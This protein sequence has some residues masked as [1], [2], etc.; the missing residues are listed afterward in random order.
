MSTVDDKLAAWKRATAKVE[1]EEKTLALLTQLASQGGTA[2]AA[3]AG[4]SVGLKLVVALIV[5][6]ALGAGTWVALTPREPRREE[7]VVVEPVQQQ[8]AAEPVVPAVP[9]VAGG[10][11]RPM[12]VPTLGAGCPA[13]GGLAPVRRRSSAP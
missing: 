1:P 6:G 4:L 3:G 11:T 7:P 2:A 5:G 9:V 10:V 8:V 13:D 12:C